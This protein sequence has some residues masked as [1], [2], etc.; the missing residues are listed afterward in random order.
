MTLRWILEDKKTAMLL[1]HEDTESGS[2]SRI[3]I[4]REQGKTGSQD[5][6][7]LF[8]DHCLDNLTNGES[9]CYSLSSIDRAGNIGT[10]VFAETTMEIS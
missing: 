1:L 7:A 10:K 8:F 2:S 9:I 5:G 6:E 4:A 3:S